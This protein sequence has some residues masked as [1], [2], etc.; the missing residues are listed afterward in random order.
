MN[1]FNITL[2]TMTEEQ[3][4]TGCSLSFR[5]AVPG[6]VAIWARMPKPR[7]GQAEPQFE[8]VCLGIVEV[9]NLMLTMA[10]VR[11]LTTC[12]EQGGHCA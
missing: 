5:G 8:D 4:A 11:T 1:T 7:K 9:P 2:G 3:H 10:A 12:P 6:K